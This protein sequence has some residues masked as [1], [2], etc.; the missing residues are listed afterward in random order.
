MR[1][2]ASF[3]RPKAEDTSGEAEN[4][5]WQAPGTQGKKGRK[6][7]NNILFILNAAPNQKIALFIWGL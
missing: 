2:G 4:R 3:R 7:V 5:A 1:R 6:S